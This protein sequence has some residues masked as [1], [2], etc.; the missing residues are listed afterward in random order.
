[1][2]KK[3]IQLH[4]MRAKAFK[5]RIIIINIYTNRRKRK[6]IKKDCRINNEKNGPI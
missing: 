3:I 5:K 4:K 2:F 6:S 1:M